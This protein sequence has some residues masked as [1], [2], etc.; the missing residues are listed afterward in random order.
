MTVG[1]RSPMRTRS[2]V[3]PLA[4]SLLW[5]AGRR[6][7]RR[8]RKPSSPRGAV[9]RKRVVQEGI[10]VEL[11]IDS[12]QASGRPAPALREGDDV[13]VRFR[14]TDTTSDMPLAGVYPGARMQLRS[15]GEVPKPDTCTD[16]ARTFIGGT[17]FSR[18]DLHLNVYHVLTLN[19]DPTITVVDPLFGFGS[20]KL[21]ALIPLES[22]GYDWALSERLRRLFVSMPEARKVAI[23]DTDG[24]Q[25]ADSIARRIRPGSCRCN[26]TSTISGSQP[27]RPTTRR[28]SPS[29]TPKRRRLRPTF[30]PAGAST[31]LPSAVTVATRSSP[32]RLTGPCRSSMSAA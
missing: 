21:L 26:P 10:A 13:A 7:P 19:D 1:A 9:V 28:G 17:L 4:V 2:T 22:R 29:W 3:V 24:W 15:D 16:K 14:I 23:V 18:A 32:T 11:T 31:L 20:T 12:R 6:P 8:S 30:R 25:V 5:L 27:T